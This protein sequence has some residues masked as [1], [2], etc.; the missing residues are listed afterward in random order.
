M[1]E[2]RFSKKSFR[3]GSS[4][5][6]VLN[7]ESPWLGSLRHPEPRLVLDGDKI[8][9]VGGDAVGSTGACRAEKPADRRSYQGNFA[10]RQQLQRH[11]GETGM[12]VLLTTLAT[13]VGTS[14]QC[15]LCCQPSCD[16][17]VS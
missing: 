2:F 5:V 13:S 15:M 7:F 1:L 11:L 4:F 17:A 3:F 8:H 10:D 14:P 12:W 6:G 9:L 16:C